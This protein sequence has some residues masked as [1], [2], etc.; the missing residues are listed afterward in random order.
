MYENWNNPLYN[1]GCKQQPPINFLK[2]SLYI[3]IS[4]VSY[5]L[6]PSPVTTRNPS[7]SSCRK[8]MFSLLVSGA[9]A[10]IHPWRLGGSKTACA[11][12]SW[13]PQHNTLCYV[14][15][16][17]TAKAKAW[18]TQKTPRH[19][20]GIF[21]WLCRHVWS[22]WLDPLPWT[23]QL[24]LMQVLAPAAVDFSGARANS[25]SRAVLSRK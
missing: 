19:C 3:H 4:P 14:N 9:R 1:L 11:T 25:Y 7:A 24:W 23:L 15:I 20:K 18:L 12:W 10:Q 21:C 6:K 22:T 2:H 8:S 13:L 5:P 16:M 17:A